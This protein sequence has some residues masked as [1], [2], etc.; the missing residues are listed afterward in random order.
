V[1][2]MTL[3]NRFGFRSVLFAAGLTTIVTVTPLALR[4]IAAWLIVD[5]PLQP[6]RAIVVL[7]GQVPFRA[8]EAASTYHHG[9]AQEIWLTEG[10]TN[11]EDRALSKFGIERD[12]EFKYSQ[13]VLERLDVPSAAIHIL[14]GAN[15]NTADEVHTIARELKA[16]GGSRVIVITSKYHTRRVRVLWR[17]LAGSGTEATVRYTPDDPFDASHWWRNTN[18]ATRVSHEW[19]G[20]LNAWAGFP[21][22][23]GR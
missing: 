23:S 9:W 12:Q 2:G 19:F 4:T 13:L 6:A 8:M 14:P 17:S 1:N 22:K 11:E 15:Q 3:R 20:L 16:R 7:G 10:A 18:D 21:L 5:D